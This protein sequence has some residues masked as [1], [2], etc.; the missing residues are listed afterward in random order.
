MFLQSDSLMF[1]TGIAYADQLIYCEVEMDEDDYKV[2]FFG[3]L[4][5]EITLNENG[6]WM[7]TSGI[8]LPESI[9]SEIG[10]R[11]EALYL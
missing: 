3:E 9:I 4:V 7:L 5:A 8:P 1:G 10:Q 2:F 6:E 11:I